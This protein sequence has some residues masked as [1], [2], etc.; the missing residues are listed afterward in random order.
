MCPSGLALCHPAADLLTKWATYG[1]STTNTGTPWTLQQMQ[2]AVERGPHRSALSD[3]AIARFR[4]EV[5]KKVKIGQAKLVAWDSIKDNPPTELKFSPIAA[6]PHKLKQFC[7][8]LA[9]IQSTTDAGWYRTVS[10]CNYC[11]NSPQGCYRPT[12]SFPHLYHSCLCGS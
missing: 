5:D 1:C 10:K 2:A 3:E 6:K 11:K 8:I 7:L 9:F 12:R 4:A